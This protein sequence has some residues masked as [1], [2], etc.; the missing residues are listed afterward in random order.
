VSRIRT[1][2]LQ[3][4][5]AIWFRLRRVRSK[6][7]KN[8]VIHLILTPLGLGG[9]GRRGRPAENGNVDAEAPVGAPASTFHVDA[10]FD[11]CYFPEGM[12]GAPPGEVAGGGGTFLGS[13]AFPPRPAFLHPAIL[14]SIIPMVIAINA[15][16]NL[17]IALSS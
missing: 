1:N 2:G 7:M 8:L 11:T 3:F 16:R 17:A 14:N 13:G 15:I 5:S 9:E 6:S 12:V 4:G 10:R